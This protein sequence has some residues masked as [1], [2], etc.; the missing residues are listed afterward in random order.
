MVLPRRIELRTSPLPTAG[1]SVLANNEKPQEI[2]QFL[3][4]F[5]GLRDFHVG[6]CRPEVDNLQGKFSSY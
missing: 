6:H 3:A 5:S 2:R 1:L 4:V